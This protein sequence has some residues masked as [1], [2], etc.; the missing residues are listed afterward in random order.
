[1]AFSIKLKSHCI[2]LVQD[3]LIPFTLSEKQTTDLVL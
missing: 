3:V 1:M 2:H